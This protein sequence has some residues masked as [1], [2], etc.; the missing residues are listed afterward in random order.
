MKYFDYPANEVIPEGAYCTPQFT[1]HE[2]YI[3]V[4]D[5]DHAILSVLM[6]VLENEGYAGLGLFESRRVY[7]FL[8]QIERSRRQG[9]MRSLPSL[10][11]LDLMMPDVSG[12]ELA[13]RLSLHP[14]LSALPIIAI[15]DDV[16]VS[17]V[18][19]VSG[20]SDLIGKPF[21]LDV[22]LEKLARY[23]SPAVLF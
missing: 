18:G 6:M 8:E 11:L 14:T 23:Q 9:Q 3:L 22:L 1:F 16:T 2:P 7:P 20:A 15:S 12:Y 19:M 17:S 13:S 10:L 4:V 21:Y 5:D